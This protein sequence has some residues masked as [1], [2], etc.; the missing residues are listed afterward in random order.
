MIVMYRYILWS[1][2]D[3]NDNDY[4]DDGGDDDDYD[5]DDDQVYHKTVDLKSDILLGGISYGLI[6]YYFILDSL[7]GTRM[8]SKHKESC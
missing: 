1:V 8:F 5:D 6:L 3:F 7:Q 2:A 4:G